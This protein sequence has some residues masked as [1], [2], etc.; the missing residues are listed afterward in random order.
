MS[1]KDAK[2]NEKR[3]EGHRLTKT[4]IWLASIIGV[5]KFRVGCVSRGVVGRL[6]DADQSLETTLPGA[7]QA[8]ADRRAVI[9]RIACPFLRLLRE[10]SVSAARLIA[11]CA[12]DDGVGFR[13]RDGQ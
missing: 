6:A 3:R 13:V 8:R 4:A 12:L 9:R 10:S 5:A 2:L 1:L 11:S 7:Q